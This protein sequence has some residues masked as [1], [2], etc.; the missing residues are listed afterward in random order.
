MARASVGR[1]A[2]GGHWPGVVLSP[3]S[4]FML[5]WHL[6]SVI[7]IKRHRNSVRVLKAQDTV[8]A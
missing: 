6:A 3:P 2:L 8:P 7:A 5:S 1:V 4:K